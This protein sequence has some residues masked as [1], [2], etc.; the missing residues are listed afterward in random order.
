MEPE[1]LQRA[2][3]RRLADPDPAHPA[4]EVRADLIHDGRRPEIDGAVEDAH[5]TLAPHPRRARCRSQHT[6]TTAEEKTSPIRFH[7]SLLARLPP[8]IYTLRPDRREKVPGYWANSLRHA[9]LRA[10]RQ[11]LNVHER[12]PRAAGPLAPRLA[13]DLTQYRGFISCWWPAWR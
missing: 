7:V 1:D 6:H 5:S 8:G 11:A 3:S 2:V 10:G 9:S 12:T 13:R 4:L